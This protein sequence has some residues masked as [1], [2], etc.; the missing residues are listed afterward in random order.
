MLLKY[1]LRMQMKYY[2]KFVLVVY[3]FKFLGTANQNG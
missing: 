2:L 3:I 1:I